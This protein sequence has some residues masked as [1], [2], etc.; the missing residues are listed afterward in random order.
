ME[1]DTPIPTPWHKAEYDSLNRE[2]SKLNRSDADFQDKYQ[3]IK[4][5]L[6]E[7]MESQPYKGKIG[8]FEGSGYSSEGL[9]RPYLNCI[10]YS[11]TL[12]GFCPV[13]S[14]AI[15]KMIRFYAQ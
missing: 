11:K 6:N 3:K 12:E 2:I 9:Y 1:K 13:C 14:A 8:A 10:M 5:R 15:E 4:K 7:S